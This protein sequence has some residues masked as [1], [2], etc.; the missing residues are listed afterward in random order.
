[1]NTKEQRF[2]WPQAIRFA[3]EG[4]G[5]DIFWMILF[6]VL[7]AIPFWASPILMARLIDLA[8]AKPGTRMVPFVT[9]TILL[10]ILV[11]QN[12]PMAL[13]FYH[14][15]SRVS[16]HSG[17]N[18]RIA[19]C[20]QLQQLSLLYHNRT[21]IGKLQTKAIR[22]IEIIERFPRMA[23]GPIFS[24]LLI[25]GAALATMALRAPKALAIFPALLATS[26][27]LSSFFHRRFEQSINQYRSSLEEMSSGLNDMLVMIPVTRAH[28]LEEQAIESVAGKIEQVARK[29]RHFDVVGGSFGASTWVSTT[30]VYSIFVSASVFLC[31]RNVFTVGDVVM[32]SAFFS[33]LSGDI[34]GLLNMMPDISQTRESMQSIKEILDAPDRE[35]N[36][37]KDLVKSVDGHF[38]FEDV[39]YCYPGT[40]G[41]GVQNLA[42][43]VAAGESIAFV[44]PSGCGKST[45]LSLLLG[46]V[47]PQ[48][49][50]ILLDGRDMASLD[51]RQYRQHVGVVTQD[52]VFFSGSIS[53]N[54]A[55]GQKG[56][57]EEEI[58]KALERSQCLE[59][60]EKLP[61]GIHSRIGADG[62]NLSGGQRQRLSIARALIRDP[63]VLIFDEATS[64]LDIPT[65]T[66]VQEAILE[67]LKGRT[68]F[69]VSHRLSTIR[70]A[71][72]IFILENGRMVS[73]GTHQE[74]ILSDNYYS[75]AHACMATSAS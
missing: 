47:R 41:A 58:W 37:H 12:Y 7:A 17:R 57:K 14:F 40:D 3:Y 20:R 69:I 23:T 1:M 75:A 22:D 33:R 9:Y 34:A 49:G 13:G 2:S 61:E 32:F 60:V 51:L 44:G 43:D 67:L 39:S 74:L 66:L 42:F 72:R 52:T 63:R 5:W 10:L 38:R 24:V 48:K 55:Y 27:V 45:T 56:V 71:S 11:L 54:V 25:S 65:E 68:S 62:L 16:R 15:G 70:H 21:N 35:E 4:H 26:V 31:F 30:L 29:G 46:F 59:F 73:S 50:R 6:Y 53:E 28:G 18:L 36:A 19:I 64:S 8:S